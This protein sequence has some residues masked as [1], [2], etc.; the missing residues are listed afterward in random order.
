MGRDRLRAVLGAAALV[1]CLAACYSASGRTP[2]AGW[3]DGPVQWLLLP[4]EQ[5]QFR[6]QR[7]AREAVL[8]IELFWRRRDPDP[9]DPGN[10]TLELFHERVQAA[11]RLYAEEDQRGSL[12]DRGGALIL[13]GPP[14][15]LRYGQEALDRS[16][17]ASANFDLPPAAVSVTTERWEYP[18]DSLSQSMLELLEEGERQQPVVLVFQ[19]RGRST[20]L[21]EGRRF[22]D[23]AAQ[24]SVRGR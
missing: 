1:M 21:V 10:E 24:A 6:R 19:E 23:I 15:I 9:T 8:F 14:P 16:L 20:R 11:D 18:M 17:P 22:L 12:T 4:E 2:A 13:L 5:R 3:A 7:N